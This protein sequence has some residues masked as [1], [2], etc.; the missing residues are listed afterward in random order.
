MLAS[1][2]NSPWLRK[3]IVKKGIVAL[4]VLLA[5]VVIVSPGILGRLAEQS[6]DENLNWAARESG[7]LVVTSEK[8]DRGWF[9]SEGQHRVELREGSFREVLSTMGGPA[10]DDELPVLVIDTRLDHGL[11]PLTSMAREKGSLAPG[12]G[13]AVSTLSI[14]FSDG[15]KVAIPGTVYSNVGLGG[16]LESSYVLE[17]GSRED[18]RSTASW[19]N[20]K[21]DV[22]T[23]PSSGDLAF[24]GNIAELSV[25]D[26]LQSFDVQELTFSG[27]Q[28]PTEFGFAVGDVKVSLGSMSVMSNGVSAGGLKSMN[29]D[30]STSVR[31]GRLSGETTLT[32]ASQAIPQFGEFSVI[33]DIRLNGADAQAVGALQQSFKAAGANPDPVRLLNATEDDL[34]KLLAAGLEVGVDKLDIDLPMGT[35]KANLHVKVAEDDAPTFEWTSLLLGTEASADISVPEAL[36]DMAMQMQPSAGTAIGMGFLQKNGD[37]YDLKA[38]YKQGLLTINGAPMPIPFGAF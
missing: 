13:S 24:N 34:K 36:V 14:E 20:S 15:E 3:F 18:G 25:A 28:E 22:T 32:M 17:A 2:R 12:L 27:S 33:A 4:L 10:T 30:G 11:I 19:G 35:V 8:F 5:L 37:V 21:I 26:G 31:K 1:P 23:D 16:A 29:V 9:S 38:E 7:D 6:V